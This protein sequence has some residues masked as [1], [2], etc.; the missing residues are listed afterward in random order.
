M[1]YVLRIGILF[2]FLVLAHRFAGA[3]ERGFGAGIL[4][5]EP[6][7]LSM[8]GWLNQTNAVD[9]GVAWSYRQSGSFHLHADYL[10]HSFHVFDTKELIPLYYG[11]G[12][13]IRTARHEDTHLGLRMTAGIDYMVRDAPFDVFFEIAPILD[14]APATE[15]EANAGI[16]ARFFFR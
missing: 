16:G 15:V 2:C 8:K 12:G 1:S 4:I 9:A 10:W 6:T 11:I 5:G 7:G 13:R 3:Q 14:L